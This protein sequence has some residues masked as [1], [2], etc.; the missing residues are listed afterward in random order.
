M[1][2]QAAKKLRNKIENRIWGRESLTARIKKKHKI[3]IKEKRENELKYGG[4]NDGEIYEINKWK[5]PKH[6]NM[7][8]METQ[9]KIILGKR[10]NDIKCK[11]GQIGADI[12]HLITC[13]NAEIT[14][15]R[16]KTGINFRQGQQHNQ[17]DTPRRY[18]IANINKC[19]ELLG[20]AGHKDR[21]K[22]RDYIQIAENEA[23][24]EKTTQ[25]LNKDED[26]IQKAADA[27][28]DE[29]INGHE[30]KEI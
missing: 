2:G 13:Q 17:T 19:L 11:C 22:F 7:K 20:E 3:R 21:E 9:W 18:A 12:E 6:C 24:E 5:M 25:Y 15:L 16:N 27:Y 29:M 1:A 26:T 23:E 30:S 4:W 28:W 8:V 10:F 14:Q